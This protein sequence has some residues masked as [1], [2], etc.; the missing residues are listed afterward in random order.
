MAGR[1]QL[2]IAVLEQQ[3]EQV[4]E[5]INNGLDVNAAD[6]DR[7][8]PLHLAV[9][10]KNTEIIKLLLDARA[11]AF[12]DSS[13]VMKTP[14]YAAIVSDDLDILHLFLDA[15]SGTD[16]KNFGYPPLHLAVLAGNLKIVKKLIDF[17]AYVDMEDFIERTPL[18]CAILYEDLSKAKLLIDSGADVN[19]SDRD[20]VTPLHL[21]AS[22]SNA[23]DALKLLLDAGARV[24]ELD[25]F[26]NTPFIN[27]LRNQENENS[28]QKI[29]KTLV[30]CTDVNLKDFF[31]RNLIGKFLNLTP[32]RPHEFFTDGRASKKYYPKIIAH[33]AML[34]K[35]NIE[36]DTNL[37]NALSN[38]NEYKNYLSKCTEELDKMKNTKLDKCWVNFFNLLVDG[39]KKIT[40]FARNQD[41]IKDFNKRVDEFSIYEPWIRINMEEGIERRKVF[42]DA[43]DILYNHLPVFRSISLIIRDILEVLSDKDW[44]KLCEKQQ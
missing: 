2:H 23:S 3:V 27:F 12:S 8:T 10:T 26:T 42:D 34:E 15:I 43:T 14:F 31:D 22:A 5:L 20:A 33:I 28:V 13:V 29:F 7:K 6:A 16:S 40:R 35:L 30:E 4:S 36:V 9:E 44:K 37:L 1:T 18:F 39:E 24:N 17:G 41:L 11:D 19:T 25:A 21:A 38:I 32:L